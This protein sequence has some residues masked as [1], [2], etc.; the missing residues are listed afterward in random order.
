MLYWAEGGKGR[1]SAIFS[2]SDVHMQRLFRRFLH[3][4]LGVEAEQMRVRVNVHTGNGL[5]VPD[6]ERYW[7]DALALPDASLRKAAVDHLPI[8][9]SGRRR[10]K[11]PTAWPP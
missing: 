1:N 8:S 7:L 11:L 9:S 4:A 6:I 3:E 5:S 10:N 2:N